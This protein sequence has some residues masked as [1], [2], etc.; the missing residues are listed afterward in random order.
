MGHQLDGPLPDLFGCGHVLCLLLLKHSIV[1]PN[2]H[3]S[4]PKALLLCRRQLLNCCLVDFTGLVVAAHA[5]LQKQ[6]VEPGV[7][8]ELVFGNKVFIDVASLAQ[9]DLVYLLLTAVLLL[10]VQVEGV[11]LL[12]TVLGDVLQAELEYLPGALVLPHL[13]FEL[14]KV[15]KVPLVQSVSSQLSYHPLVYAS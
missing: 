6:Q 3:V 12:G 9:H 15:Q 10:E 4:P 8:V 2:V 13:Y 7:I 14:G 1:V 5:L 11:Q